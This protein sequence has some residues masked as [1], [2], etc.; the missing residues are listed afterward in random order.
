MNKILEQHLWVEKW[1]PKSLDDVVMPKELREKFKEMIAQEEIPHLMFTGSA[2]VGKTTVAKI[3]MVSIPAEIL[4]L[5]SSLSRG[6]DTIRDRVSSFAAIKGSKPWRV[7]LLEEADGLTPEAQESLRNI[8]EQFSG[9]LRFILNVNY[10][11]KIIEPIKSRCQQVAFEDL[12]K[13][14]CY[15]RLKGI[16]DVE[17][18]KYNSD[19]VLEIVE[20]AYPD[21][22]SMIQMAQ[23]STTAGQLKEIKKDLDERLEVLEMVK[24]KD[25]KALWSIA[26]RLDHAGI[27]SYLFR[28][29]DQIEQDSIRRVEKML[30]IAEYERG[31]SFT[32]DKELQFIACIME[33]MA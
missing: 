31:L 10:P 17:K 13:K 26:Y 4:E 29:I 28:H 24:K 33:V 20:L 16:L 9:R 8:M 7:I 5:N 21:M 3:L 32:A 27:F 25:I 22:R 14:E 1:R 12:S 18:V 19:T 23:L 15:S 2:G 6:I 30:K 11:N